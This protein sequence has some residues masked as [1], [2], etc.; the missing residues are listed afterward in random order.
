MLA[1][2]SLSLQQLVCLNNDIQPLQIF[3]WSL[4]TDA[5]LTCAAQHL[6]W[7]LCARPAALSPV[8][9][10]STLAAPTLNQIKQVV[11]V[12]SDCMIKELKAPSPLA[13][14]RSYA[15]T[16]CFFTTTTPTLKA[17]V[18]ACASCE[19]TIKSGSETLKQ[20]LWTGQDIIWDMSKVIDLLNVVLAAHCLSSEDVTLF[21][22]SEQSCFIW[23]NHQKICQV[24]NN[25]L[26]VQIKDYTVLIYRLA[27]DQ[28]NI[29][30]QQNVMCTFIFVNS[31]WNSQINIIQTVWTA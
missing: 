20:H 17:H 31:Q 23:E 14:S 4:D 15:E 19:I 3:I 24:F 6:I 27:Q 9:T 22:N 29:S 13:V 11:Q 10:L 12:K 5:L 18:L 16:A 25:E 7:A 21:F 1:H 26:I 30:N 28:I 2:S 8:K